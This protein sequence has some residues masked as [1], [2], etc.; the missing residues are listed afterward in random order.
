MGQPVAVAVTVTGVPTVVDPTG[1]VAKVNPVQLVT[2][3]VRDAKT[4][5]VPKLLL[6]A[7]ALPASRTHTATWYVP[8]V[9][10]AVLQLSELLL[11]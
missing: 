7:P 6:K 10:P 1:A 3:K 2:V 4:S 5:H 8:G 9:L 11:E